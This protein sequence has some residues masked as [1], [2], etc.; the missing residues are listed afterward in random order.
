MLSTIRAG[1]LTPRRGAAARESAGWHAAL[2]LAALLALLPASAM[3][4]EDLPRGAIVEGVK[5]ASAPGQSYVLYLPAGY[6]P[7]R[8]WPILYA[9][10]PSGSGKRPVGAFRAAAEKYGYVVVGSNDSRNGLMAA[11]LKQI[12]NALWQD[13]HERFSIDD[14]RV[15]AAGFSGGARV[16]NGLA[17]ACGG[18]VAGVI[19]SGAGFPP[20]IKPTASLPYAFFGTVGVDDFNFREMRPLERTLDALDV[21]NRLA[22]FDGRHQWCPEE[23]C[24]EG[25]E[26]MELLAMRH[27]RRPKDD[28]FIDGALARY[29]ARA[30]KL[31]RPADAYERH[32]AL[33]AIAQTFD[34]L[35]DVGRYGAEAAALKKT[36]E[37]RAAFAAEERQID[38]EQERAREL[39]AEGGALVD[40]AARDDA[41]VRI[42]RLAATLREQAKSAEDGGARRVARRTLAHVYAETFES[43]MYVYEPRKEFKLAAANLELAAE[44]FPAVAGIEFDLARMLALGGRKDRALSALARAADKGYRDA[45]A[46]ERE[47]AFAPLRESAKFKKVIER[48]RAAPEKGNE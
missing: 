46:I 39:I 21:V 1:V 42:R 10:D 19:S 13:T 24:A 5:V 14:A 20:V 3:A 17:V 25:I 29:T 33:R 41:L 7:D 47:E 11:P 9:F 38:E 6:T 2:S 31:R 44:V 22:T 34:G 28:A 23:V 12:I 27:G 15:Y 36:K 40:D 32:A 30:E 48:V 35:R 26:W 45:A 4:A 37:F 16:A 8:K 18:C 43:A